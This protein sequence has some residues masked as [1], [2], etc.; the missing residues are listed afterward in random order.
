LTSVYMNHAIWTLRAAFTCLGLMFGTWLGLIPWM[1]DTRALTHEQVGLALLCAGVGGLLTFPL[2]RHLLARVGSAKLVVA[3]GI[4]MAVCLPFIAIAPNLLW[5]S[6]SLFA[7]GIPAATMDVAI[8]AQAVVQERQAKQ[9]LMARFHACWSLGALTGALAAVVALSWHVPL[10]IFMA[11]VGTVCGLGLWLNR[12]ALLQEK[13]DANTPRRAPR[14][15]LNARVLLVGSIVV[16]AYMVE[17]AVSDWSG[18]F[19][20]DIVGVSLSQAPMAFAAFS[21]AMVVV[22]LFGDPVIDALGNVR[23]LQLS[24]S[25]GALGM[26]TSLVA[27]NVWVVLPAYAVVGC[28]MA[29]AVPVLMRCAGQIDPGSGGQA[30][31][32]VAFMGTMGMLIAPPVLGWL[33]HVTSLRSALW[34]VPLFSAYIILQARRAVHSRQ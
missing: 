21:F 8:N 32:T 6:V 9:S 12:H 28:G 25:L 5:L 13:R 24:G 14:L 2:V 27:P 10:W 18:L 26:A 30:L 17:G 15:Q 23:V 11:M 29:L 19:M 1:R 22:R 34:L 7:V 33:A 31:A 20:R 16:C 3:S 4:A